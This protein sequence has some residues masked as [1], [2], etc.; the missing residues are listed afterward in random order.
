MRLIPGVEGI[1]RKGFAWVVPLL[2][3]THG[4]GS[5][6]EQ[7]PLT[8]EPPLA[9]APTVQAT[10]PEP[11][12]EN[13]GTWRPAAVVAPTAAN[14]AELHLV[15]QAAATA[16]EPA[17]GTS[18]APMPPPP[19][20]LTQAAPVAKNGVWRPAT[21]PAPECGCACDRPSPSPLRFWANAEYLVW[22]VKDAPVGNGPIVTA[23]SSLTDRPPGALGQPGTAVLFGQ[24]PIGYGAFSGLRI[25]GGVGLCSGLSLDGSYFALE[26]RSSNFTAASDPRGNPLLGIAI[27]NTAI[28]I[29]DALLTSNPDVAVGPWSGNAIVL[30]HLRLQGWD[31]NAGL[32]TWNRGG[33]TIR[34][35]VGFRAM[36]LDEDLSLSDVF[37]PLAPGTLTFLG[38]AVPEN[39]VLTDF[40]RFATTNHFY[41]G[42]FGGQVNWQRGAFKLDLTGK[43]ALGA[44]QQAVAIAGASTSTPPGGTMAVAPGGIYAQTSNIGSYSRSVFSVVPEFGVTLGWN[45]RPNITATLGYSVLYWSNVVRPGD[46]VDHGVNQTLVPTHQFFGLTPSDGRPAFAFHNADFWAQGINIGVQFRY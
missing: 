35:L 18:P 45:I 22:W 30:S 27:F 28:G 10:R 31:L 14:L 11:Y 26:R 37:T 17:T 19:S 2:L 13:P 9:S 32:S 6:Q 43:V 5:A 40:D 38:A 24:S 21:V 8:A 15:L 34:G 1:M 29:E 3:V 23:S 46:Q 7:A 39:T 4:L 42:Q 41:G 36:R 25:S 44:N 33:V 20:P 16:P 12:T